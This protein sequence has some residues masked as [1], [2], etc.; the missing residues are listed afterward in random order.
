MKPSSGIEGRLVIVQIYI[1]RGARLIQIYAPAP[2]Y[3]DQTRAARN[4]S[5]SDPREAEALH[6]AHVWWSFAGEQIKRARSRRLMG[7]SLVIVTGLG[8]LG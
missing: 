2:V 7:E 5:A 4:R 8:T 3:L 6:H 1:A